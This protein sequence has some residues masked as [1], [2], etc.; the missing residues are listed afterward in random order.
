VVKFKKPVKKGRAK[1]Y[2]KTMGKRNIRVSHSAY[3]DKI[4]ICIN[5]ECVLR[6][7]TKCFGFEGCPGFKSR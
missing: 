6:K 4:T 7:K 2:N 3:G 1:K 5:F